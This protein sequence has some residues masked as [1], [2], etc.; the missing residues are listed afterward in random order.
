[1]YPCSTS[2]RQSQM[3]IQE[4]KQFPNFIY[5][6]HTAHD[7]VALYYIWPMKKKPTNGDDKCN[8]QKN[9]A[10]VNVRSIVPFSVIKS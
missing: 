6:I 3:R 1:M 2:L 9:V 7:T 4:E 5:C 10:N 8:V